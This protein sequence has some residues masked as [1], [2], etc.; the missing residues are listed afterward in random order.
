MWR[1]GQRAPSEINGIDGADVFRRGKGQLTDAGIARSLELGAALRQRYVH[2][3]SLLSGTAQKKEEF[4]FYSTNVARCKHTLKLVARAMFSEEE[5]EKLDPNITVQTAPDYLIGFQWN[6]CPALGKIFQEKCADWAGKDITTI[7]NYADFEAL[8]FACSKAGK[9]IFYVSSRGSDNT[10]YTGARMVSGVCDTAGRLSDQVLARKMVLR[11]QL[12]LGEYRDEKM[13]KLA[14][15]FLLHTIIQVRSTDIGNSPCSSPPPIVRFVI[16]NNR[17]QTCLQ[18][19]QTKWKCMKDAVAAAGPD[20]L[21]SSITPKQSFRKLA[22]KGYSTHDYILNLLL[23]LLGGEARNVALK[24]F[25]NPQMSAAIGIEL[26]D[27]AGAPK[28]KVLYRPYALASSLRELTPV[29]EHCKGEADCDLDKFQAGYASVTTKNPLEEAIAFAF[30][31]TV[32]VFGIDYRPYSR[33]RVQKYLSPDDYH[34]IIDAVLSFFGAAFC[35]YVAVHWHILLLLFYFDIHEEANN[36][37]S[38]RRKEDI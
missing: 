18:D 25:L 6:T 28:V 14:V 29:I 37:S 11:Y 17:N 9:H 34:R 35:V 19:M 20:C 2:K 31:L 4:I 12:G 3:Y 36:V 38:R 27:V 26:W 15:G 24:G 30:W 1:H 23:E 33:H 22:F 5:N 13:L 21:D 7:V 8:S 16:W 32:S 10:H